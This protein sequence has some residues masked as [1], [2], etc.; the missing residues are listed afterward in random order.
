MPYLERF[1]SLQSVID[2]VIR[3]GE[4]KAFV[5]GV[6]TFVRHHDPTKPVVPVLLWPGLAD[7]TCTWRAGTWRRRSSKTPWTV[8]LVEAL[9]EFFRLLGIGLLKA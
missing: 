6:R 2:E 4:D 3:E 5:R 7:V 8:D 9:T 1:T